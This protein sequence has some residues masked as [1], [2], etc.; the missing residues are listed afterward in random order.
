MSSIA[1]RVRELRAKLGLN[2]IA[3]AKRFGVTQSTVSKWE[4]GSQRPELA[5][6]MQMAEAG[7]YDPVKFALQDEE[8]PYEGGFGDWGREVEVVGAINE[9]KGVE[10]VFWDKEDRFTFM[11]PAYAPWRNLRLRGFVIQD[12]SADLIYPKDSIVVAAEFSL[13]DRIV[14]QPDDIIIFRL[15]YRDTELHRLTV[16]KYTKGPADTIRMIPMSLDTQGL[17][18]LETQTVTIDAS[19]PDVFELAGIMGVIVGGFTIY[20]TDRFPPPRDET[21][22]F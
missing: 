5:V 12:K 15:R 9:S 17:P 18:F 22:P 14:P 13:A 1:R 19:A 8:H 3:F 16:R 11:V 2:Q 10:S 7:G 4:R 6:A 20:N 21:L